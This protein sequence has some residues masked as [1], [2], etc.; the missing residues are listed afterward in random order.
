MARQASPGRRSVLGPFDGLTAQEERCRRTYHGRL[1]KRYMLPLF[2]RGPLQGNGM[3]EPPAIIQCK[4]AL[5]NGGL[6]AQTIRQFRALILSNHQMHGRDLPWRQTTDPYH[7]LVSEVMLQQTQ[8][9]RV[10]DKYR[11]F[12]AAFPDF[13][14]LA[15]ASLQEVLA[16]WVGLGYNR[17]ALA[18]K[19]TAKIVMREYCGR[20]PASEARLVDLPG[21]GKYTA[22]AIL[23]F[24]FGQPVILLETNIRTVFLYFFFEHRTDVKDTE[25]IP[26][27]AKTLT[28]ANPR[29]WYNALMDYGVMLKSMHP[30]PNR[31][32]AHYHKQSSFQ[33][34]GRQIRGMIVKMLTQGIPMSERE[35]LRKVAKEPDRVKNIL[36]QLE[37]EKFV[38]KKG[39]RFII[40]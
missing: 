29:T 5:A 11:Q 14:S 4:H 36:L 32:S 7:I 21:V 6:N 20:L 23:V 33:G 35:I 38:K 40:A 16:V 1:G 30:N 27:V 2:M 19:N 13:A 17:R 8:V 39:R 12:I 25:I 26:L 31:R 18:L 3:S 34:S 24:A 22:S 10:I 15:R 9:D 28:K 37:K